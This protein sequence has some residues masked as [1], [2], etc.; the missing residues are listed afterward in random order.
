MAMNLGDIVAHLKLEIGDFTNKLNEA[1]SSIDDTSKQ[2]DGLTQ[3]GQSLSTVGTALTAGVTAP[4]VALGAAAIKT[5]AD[6]STAMSKVQALSGASGE[7]LQ[8]LERWVQQQS[9]QLLRLL[10]L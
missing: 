5:G 1:K 6:F 7:E 8:K 4:V 10:M 2:F 3:A 9:T